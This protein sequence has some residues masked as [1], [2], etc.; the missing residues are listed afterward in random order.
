MLSEIAIALYVVAAIILAV[1]VAIALKKNPA[2]GAEVKA[3]FDKIHASFSSLTDHLQ[4]I[5]QAA[6]SPTAIAFIPAVAPVA[7]APLPQPKVDAAP[8][9]SPFPANTTDP[10]APGFVMP[11]TLP[12]A[13][14]AAA[15]DPVIDFSASSLDFA[16]V[17]GQNI[18]VSGTVSKKFTGCPTPVWVQTIN[19][20]GSTITA[21]GASHEEPNGQA[22]NRM[23]VTPINGEVNVTVV[24]DTSGRTDLSIL[25]APQ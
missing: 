5:H 21:N 16:T 4:L 1:G 13:A 24:C 23:T 8:A 22:L 12:P 6:S 25:A 7:P 18:P 15:P 14:P 10:T 3:E 11:A 9:P 19:G 20:S 17:A 2:L